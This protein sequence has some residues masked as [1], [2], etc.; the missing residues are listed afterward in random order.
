M[1]PT[2]YL[3]DDDNL[4]RIFHCRQPM[5]DQDDSTALQIL[6]DGLLYLENL[7]FNL[8]PAFSFFLQVL[9]EKSYFFK[10]VK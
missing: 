6:L 7:N 1:P 9:L 4:V 3:V 5:R 8:A 2:S 10:H